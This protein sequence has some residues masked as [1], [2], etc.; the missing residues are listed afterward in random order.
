MPNPQEIATLIVNGLRFEDWESV[1]VQVRWADAF[2]YFRF[3]AAER[4]PIFGLQGAPQWTKLQFKP[5]DTCTVLLA[6]QLVITGFIETR[7]VAYDQDNHGVMLIG[8]SITAGAAKSSVDTETGSLDGKNL[9]QIAREITAPYPVGIKTIGNVDGTP[10]E[11][12]QV[13][14]GENIWDCMERLAR[15]RGVIMGADA[16][17]N[18]LLIG[19]H[20]MPV[21]ADLV[22]GINIKSCQCVISHEH[23][24]KELQVDGQ[25]APGADGGSGTD[26]SEIT[27]HATGVAEAVKSKLIIPMEQ[28]GTQQEAQMRVNHEAK[29]TSGTKITAT[30]VVQGWLRGG[31]AI[32]QAGDDVYVRSPMAMLDEVLKIRTVDLLQDDGGGMDHAGSSIRDLR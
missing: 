24:Y 27:A 25:K 29:W 5:G 21:I 16:L 30:I 15:M 32:W 6:G 2:S 4:D 10:F 12:C 18:F 26:L 31:G 19:D 28:P 7:Q 17:G 8:K 14:K 20:S 11:K 9:Q 3:T 1:W 22:E 13:Q 23:V